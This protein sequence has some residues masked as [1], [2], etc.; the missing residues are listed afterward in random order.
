MIIPP[1]EGGMHDVDQ[2]Q[3]NPVTSFIWNADDVLRDIGR[4]SATT[5][6]PTSTASRRTCTTSSTGGVAA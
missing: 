6:R 3:L 2:A 4:R 5:S 1:V